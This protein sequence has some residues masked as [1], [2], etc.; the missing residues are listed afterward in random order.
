[1]TTKLFKPIICFQFQ[2]EL[3]TFLFLFTIHLLVFFF[4]AIDKEPHNGSIEHLQN[5]SFEKDGNVL[6]AYRTE[7]EQNMEYTNGR[8][9][10]IEEFLCILHIEY[11]LS[12][13]RGEL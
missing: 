10:Y 2:N 11:L 3:K 12:V 7:T 4:F 13:M 8:E 1:M 5:H 6:N 9:N